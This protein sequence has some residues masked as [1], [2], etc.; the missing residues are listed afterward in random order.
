MS[1]QLVYV[2]MG[3]VKSENITIVPDEAEEAAGF[4]QESVLRMLKTGRIPCDVS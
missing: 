2:C 3:T 1:D 4:D